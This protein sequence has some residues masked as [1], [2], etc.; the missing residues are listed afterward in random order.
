MYTLTIHVQRQ[1]RI[2]VHSYYWWIVN[3]A[4]PKFGELGK[5][6]NIR[7]CMITAL[8]T[9]IVLMLIKTEE[10]LQFQWYR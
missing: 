7:H 9:G 10:N 6:Y 4:S 5:Q 1:I 8:Y 3:V 2:H